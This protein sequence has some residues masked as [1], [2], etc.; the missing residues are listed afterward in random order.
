MAKAKFRDH[1]DGHS[2][3]EAPQWSEEKLMILDGYLG[4]GPDRRGGFAQ[5]CSRSRTGWYSLDL[6]AGTGLNWSQTRGEFINGSPRIALEAGPPSARKVIAAERDERC[7][8][9]L[10][11]RTAEYGDRVAL[12]NGDAN[13]SIAEMLDLVPTNAPAFAFL[14]PEGSELDWATVEAIASHKTGRSNKIEQLALF[15]SDMGIVRLIPAYPEKVDR[16]FGHGRWRRIA[17]RR[18]RDSITPEQ[19]RT[20]YV[21]LYAEGFAGLGYEV[22]LDRQITKATGHPMYFLLFATDHP[23]G[24]KIMDHAFDV[25]E[26]RVREE[27]G[28]GTLFAAGP[29]RRVKRLP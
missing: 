7:F 21:K 18:D 20:L 17:E 9:A 8:A 27:L 22:C 15:P 1:P 2:A 3:R 25:S 6:F 23:A 14:D 13:E 11:T 24:R 28:Q 29:A 4:G 10:K 12:F 26:I 16:I 19:A 5:A